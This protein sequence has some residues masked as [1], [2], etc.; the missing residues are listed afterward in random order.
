MG[1]R[2]HTCI[3]AHVPFGGLNNVTFTRR[4]NHIPVERLGGGIRLGTLID[5]FWS[6]NTLSADFNS[7]HVQKSTG[8]ASID[9]EISNDTIQQY[10]AKLSKTPSGIVQLIAR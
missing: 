7:I 1:D 6:G 10:S 8:Y 5:V 3:H 9:F 4:G 2:V